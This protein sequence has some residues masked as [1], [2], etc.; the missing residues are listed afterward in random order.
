MVPH[1]LVLYWFGD[2]TR[3]VQGKVLVAVLFRDLAELIPGAVAREGRLYL[4]EHA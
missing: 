2:S 3:A 1:T 4:G